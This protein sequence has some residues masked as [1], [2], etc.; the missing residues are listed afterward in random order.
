MFL[1]TVTRTG[2]LIFGTP[3]KGFTVTQYVIIDRVNTPRK[4]YG[5]FAFL[6]DLFL[7]ILTHGLW[8]I[9]IIIRQFIK[10]RR[11]Y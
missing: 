7:T 8:I 11:R 5:C 1:A 10:R 6:L 9:W 2:N 4:P 3:S